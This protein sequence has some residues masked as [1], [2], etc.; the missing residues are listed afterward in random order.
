V[1]FYGL[2]Q[3]TKNTQRGILSMFYSEEL[4]TMSS[5]E[6]IKKNFPLKGH[7]QCK[8]LSFS[9]GLSHNIHGVTTVLSFMT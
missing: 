7:E 6:K 5:T 9:P 8:K 3:I 1:F 2:T 4:T